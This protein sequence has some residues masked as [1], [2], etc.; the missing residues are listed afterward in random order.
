MKK[1]AQ[2]AQRIRQLFNKLKKAG[3]GSAETWQ[4]EDPM[5]MLLWAILSTYAS[6]A[7]AAAALAKIRAAMVDYNELRVTP[8][9]EIVEMIGADYPM[10]RPAAEEIV[11]TLQAIFN[12]L[13]HLNLGFLKSSARRTA[14]SFLNTLDGL[15]GH[16]KA[17]MVLRCFKGHAVPLDV[18]MYAFLH[19][20]GRIAEGAAVEQAQ[21]FLAGVIK[22]R[23]AVGFYELLK[24]YAAAH[25]PRKPAPA[26]LA[27]A[28]AAAATGRREAAAESPAKPVAVAQ[29]GKAASTK[30]VTG[31][32]G[33]RLPAKKAAK[34][35]AG[36]SSRST[37]RVKSSKNA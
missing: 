26:R 37:A 27:T 10:C 8:V 25:A 35:K 13:H 7:R 17:M 18:N 31:S 1:D 15:G 32:S 29:A 21:R 34:R 6:E 3:G 24:R 19:K 4:S 12:R 33:K 14:E 36:G 9:A 2:Y 20:N 22:E 28:P 23:D 30:A 5:E 16:A 11:R